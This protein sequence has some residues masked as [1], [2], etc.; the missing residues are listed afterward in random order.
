MAA[1][2]TGAFKQSP[3]S[4]N[5]SY[6]YWAPNVSLGGNLTIEGNYNAI[7]LILQG[8]IAH[9]WR[10]A[11]IGTNQFTPTYSNVSIDYTVAVDSGAGLVDQDP[12]I[13]VLNLQTDS[14]V[15]T[16]PLGL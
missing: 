12:Q 1:Y 7:N 2:G 3:A 11:N 10:G 14:T 6:T 9:N 13:T 4:I 5:S 8:R 16:N 15:R